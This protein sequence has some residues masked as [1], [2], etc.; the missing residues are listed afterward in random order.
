[1]LNVDEK[2]VASEVVI[3]EPASDGAQDD[4]TDTDD[5]SIE[6]GTADAVAI[7]TETGSLELPMPL[8][9]SD[10]E[11][12]TDA[13]PLMKVTGSGAASPDG[14]EIHQQSETPITTETTQ[15]IVAEAQQHV[16]ETSDTSA[17]SASSAHVA[18]ALAAEIGPPTA[19][20][21]TED[22]SHRGPATQPTLDTFFQNDTDMLRNFLDRVKAEKA[23]KAAATPPKIRDD[24]PSPAPDTRSPL[25]H[26]DRNASEPR[27]KQVP[28]EAH[29]AAEDREEATTIPCETAQEQDEEFTFRRSKRLRR[30]SSEPSR[31]L[32]VTPSFI[33]RRRTDGPESLVLQKTPAQELAILTRIN[34][35][36]NKG[37]PYTKVLLAQVNEKTGAEES[38][39][40]RSAA[41]KTV[42]WANQLEHFQECTPLEAKKRKS[43]SRRAIGTPAR[44]RKVRGPIVDSLSEE[45]GGSGADRLHD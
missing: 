11:K 14:T 26:R 22:S 9:T 8:D 34:T 27:V 39:T 3:Q 6:G 2:S 44:K 30:Q 40:G 36:C 17:P 4:R 13:L 15:S 35:R 10:M 37:K 5:H 32:S 29:T 43:T 12:P 20:D 24:L 19:S 18:G 1:M 38:T 23:A 16:E 41:S 45:V 33:P 31:A 7:M 21:L 28:S 25:E 42:R